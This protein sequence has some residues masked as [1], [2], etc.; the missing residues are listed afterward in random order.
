[1]LAIIGRDIRLALRALARRPLYAFI[2]VVTLGIGIGANSAMFSIID[3]ALIRDLPFRDAGHLM[4][5]SLTIKSSE[6][7]RIAGRGVEDRVV[8]SYP[9]FVMLRDAQRSFSGVAAYSAYN[10]NLSGDGEAERLRVELVSGNYFDILQVQPARGRVLQTSD[11]RA[12]NASPVVVLSHALWQRRFA[13]NGDIVGRSI[14]INKKPYT[15]LGVA[16][17]GFSG[18]SGNADF[19]VPMSM[20]P[21]IYYD[22][23]LE[24]RW[25]HW[26]D[27]IGRL[28]HDV[29]PA[30]ANDELQGLGLRIA[31]AFR[32]PNDGSSA[33][34]AAA[35]TLREARSDATLRRSILLL[36]GAVVLVLLIACANVANMSLARAEAVRHDAAVRVAIG[37]GQGRLF[38]QHLVESVV[39]ALLGAVVGLL[40]AVWALDA[41]R[42][43]APATLA[44][45]STQAAQFLDLANVHVDR[46]VLLFT[47]ALGVITGVLF[48]LIP[49]FHAARNAPADSLKAGGRSF[50][51]AA[52]SWRRWNTRSALVVADVALSLVLLIAAGLMLRSLGKLGGLDVGFE[53]G[54]LL[55]FR[56][57]PPQDSQYNFRTSPRMKEGILERLRALPG[58]RSA[59]VNVCAPLTASCNGSVVTRVA[60]RPPFAVDA[61]PPIGVH[62]VDPD[63]FTTLSIALLRGRPFNTADRR[64]AA[65][66]VIINETAARRL[67]PNEDPVGK[68]LSIGIG[69]LGGGDSLGTIVGVVGDVQYQSPGTEQ[70]MDAYVPALAY[71]GASSMFLIRTLGE[72]TAAIPGVRRALRDFDAA[73]PIFDVQTMDERS[74][75]ALS[76]ARFGAFLLSVF[77]VIALALAAV[78]IYGVVAYSVAQ[79]RREIGIRLALGAHR[80]RVLRLVVGQ[81]LGL[82]GVGLT[83][84]VAGAIAASRALGTLLFNTSPLDPTTY[85]TLAAALASVVALASFVPA[86]AASRLDP[87]TVLRVE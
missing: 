35:R 76:T 64:G 4:E 2:T 65:R 18:L 8:W 84:G 43:L 87:V 81:M 78:G 20:A 34:G 39:V 47:S 49:A 6:R 60:G 28:R 55:T 77:G 48:G 54:N 13:G 12:P 37:A 70:G 32:A 80:S 23:A 25:S 73:L 1:M 17:A 68:Q 41:V 42:A 16:P 44:P 58:V 45:A 75:R 36:G 86:R 72:P 9:K 7:G 74:G 3:A 51:A 56:V 83:L 59:S 82:A 79:R 33:W 26:L 52:G 5:L 57:Q 21:T 50:T 24:E 19:W 61:A 67:F 69:Y 27:V 10:V 85:I 71:G 31:E 14:S 46:R 22:R 11:D 63:F 53:S 30:Q 29:T 66:V 38:R 15:V 62:S 40:L